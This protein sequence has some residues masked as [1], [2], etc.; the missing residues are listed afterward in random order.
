MTATDRRNFAP[1]RTRRLEAGWRFHRGDVADGANPGIP[2]DGWER[3]TVP[4]DW[5]IEG[6]FDP[7]NP[8]GQ[9][10]GFAP[11]GVGWYRRRLPEDLAATSRIR[12]DGVYRDFDV[13]VDG[14]HVG[15]R[16]YGYSTVTYDLSSLALDGGEV[17]AVRVDNSTYP[18]SRWYTGSGI[19]RDVHLIETGSVA[20]EPFGVDVRVPAVTATQATVNVRTHIETAGASGPI[21]LETTVV[22]PSGDPVAST[23]T[24]VTGS[25]DADPIEQHLD[26]RNPER[27]TLEDPTRY[28]VTSVVTVENERVDEVH[29][30]FGIRTIAWTGEAGFFLNDRPVDLKG[31]NLHH[32]A[33][34]L[35]A[36]VTERALERRLE[37]LQEL[38]CNA[39]RTAHNPPNPHLLELCD[40]MGILVIDELYDKWRHEGVDAWF[41]DWWEADLRSLVRRDRNHPSVV[42]WS[43]G[44]EQYNHGDAE[45]LADLEAL[46]AAT[47][48]L[49]PTRPVTYGNPPWGD[50]TDG[51]VENITAVAQHVDVLSCNYQEHWYDD[52]RAAGLDLPIVGSECRAYFRGDGDDPLAF[53]P[54]NPWYDVADRDDVCG[55]FIWSGADYLGES[56]EW[57]SKGWAAGLLDTTGAIKPIA[58]FHQAAWSEEPMVFAAPVDPDRERPAVRPPWS[59]PPVAE[60]WTFPEQANSQGFVRVVT[61]TNAD[62]VQLELNGESLGVQRADR[63]ADRPPEWDVPYESG[64]LRA[65][66]RKHDEIVAE[67]TLKTA[68]T[69][70]RVAVETDRVELAS[71]G[72]DLAYVTA[73][74]RD[75][76][77][78]RVPTADHRVSFTL[79]GPGEIAG[80]DNG[81]LDSDESWVGTD[82][83]A[84]RG[85]C[86]AVVKSDRE[87]G[88]IRV[89]ATAD[90]LGSASLTIETQEKTASE[91]R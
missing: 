34:C 11:G 71:D 88:T 72:R 40:Q 80:V 52:Y 29:T 66:G 24:P 37:T 6:P 53:V 67:H 82:R 5:S 91:N 7:D 30:D 4:H 78:T 20:I 27:W 25:S 68:A 38:G 73:T 87:P 75:T 79:E 55:Q 60:H 3:V 15:S 22:D 21:A 54:R 48:R 1:R 63:H 58:R 35:G 13:Y 77:G 9:Q 31:V 74:I 39:I 69:P 89:R 62:T 42:C 28:S 70:E 10:Q 49:D 65:I 33:G 83:S 43:V 41:D 86:I 51:V 16:P 85:R 19:Y 47:H 50:G 36:A 81:N 57:P 17:L 12:F 8:G 64:E 76:N 61:V 90:E 23:T 56:R 2:D 84:F 46:V 26:V 59:W 14:H 32:D 18:H 45:M 44:N